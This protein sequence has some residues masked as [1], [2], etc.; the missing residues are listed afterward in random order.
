MGG[1]TPY[2]AA[3]NCCQG[4]SQE[5]GTPARL[6]VEHR[7]SVGAVNG[8][9]ACPNLTAGGSPLAVVAET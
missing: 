6:P 9:L 4:I 7:F 2:Q 5:A 1:V 8:F 3:S